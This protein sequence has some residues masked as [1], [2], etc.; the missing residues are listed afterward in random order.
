[1]KKKILFI[2]NHRIGRS[3]GQRFRFEQYLDFIEENNFEVHFSNIISEE[4]DVFLYQKGKYFKKAN[5]ARKTW[6]IRLKNL[7]NANNYDIIFIFREALLT[8]STYFEKKF[9]KS[10]AKIIFDFDDAI[11]LPNVSAGNKTLQFFKNPKKTDEILASSD[12]VFAGNQFLADYASQFCKNVKVIPTTIDTNYHIRKKQ[13]NSDSI[14]I[15]WTGTQTTLKYLYLLDNVFKE[16]SLKYKNKIY[17]K[18][19][20]DVPFELK[21]VEIKNEKWCKD[22]EIEQ[23]EEIDIGIMPLLDDEWSQGKCGFKGL[24]Y[25]AMNSVALLSPVGVNKEIIIND[26]NGFLVQTNEEWIEKLSLLIDNAELR[27]RLGSNARKTIEEK[28]S[29]NAHKMRYINYFNELLK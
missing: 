7:A 26:Y 2:A 5:L 29:V 20:C 4:D 9:A 3:P 23:L 13:N 10:K 22:T 11:W 6:G 1:M 14:C 16:L 24:Q 19:I 27:A 15:G 12:M 25:M 21:G 28:Y 18:V 17:F 8:G